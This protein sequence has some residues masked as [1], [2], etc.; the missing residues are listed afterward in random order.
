MAESDDSWGAWWEGVKETPVIGSVLGAGEGAIT[1]TIGASGSAV[2]GAASPV[3]TH[4]P[5]VF[6]TEEDDDDNDVKQQVADKQE[7]HN[8]EEK[9]QAILRSAGVNQEGINLVLSSPELVQNVLDNPMVAATFAQS[10]PSGTAQAYNQAAAQY[11]LENPFHDGTGGGPEGAAFAA[12]GVPGSSYM[13]NPN[14]GGFK[15]DN[16]VIVDPTQGIDGVLFPP[17]DATIPGSDAWLNKIQDNWSQDKVEKWRKTLSEWG[18]DISLKGGFDHTFLQTLQMY[19]KY[20][21]YNRYKVIPLDSATG[22]VTRK[23]FDGALDRT[24]LRDEVESWADAIG[25]NLHEDDLNY[26]ADRVADKA[27]KIASKRGI[28]PGNAA[29]IAQAKVQ[30]EFEDRPEVSE[31]LESI[32]DWQMDRGLYDTYVSV[33]QIVGGTV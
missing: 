6:P 7:A 33:A 28:S 11:G 14:T 25:M 29:R 18:A 30:N 17:A 3:G 31:R 24:I 9:A 10:Y 2:V 4:I 15:L 32:D 27:M 5:D 23:D 12:A 8:A 20:R 21:Y 13:T 16:G 1:G 19:H 22:G 26:L